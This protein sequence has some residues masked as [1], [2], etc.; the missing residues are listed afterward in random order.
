[1]GARLIAV[2]ASC[3]LA[4]CVRDELVACD[5]GR[6]CPVG[7]AC[8]LVHATCVTPAQT[9]VCAPLVDGDRCDA[10]GTPGICDGN[11]CV[12]GC[13]DGH[14]DTGEECDDG[15]F[16]SRDGCSSA[17]LRE[18]ATWRPIDSPW[19]GRQGHVGAYMAAQK[20]FVVFGGTRGN[21]VLD[22]QWQRNAS[23]TWSPYT[24]TRPSARREAVMV[25]D[26][27][28]Q[29]LVLFGGLDANDTGLDD[30]WEFDGTTWTKMTPAMSPSA[31]WGSGMAFVASSS[32]SILFGGTNVGALSDTWTYDGVTWAPVSLS[33]HPPGR[34][35]HAMTW[36]AARGVVVLYGGTG[37]LF[38]A[39]NDTWELSLAGWIERQIPGP[40]A[41][42]GAVL[43]Y[44][45]ARGKAVLF[46]GNVGNATSDTWEYD[47]NAWTQVTTGLSTPP[48][49]SQATLA[50]DT[51]GEL[52]LVGGAKNFAA[53]ALDDIWLYNTNGKWGDRTPLLTP[54]PRTAPLVYDPVAQRAVLVS[55]VGI[56]L[57]QD[58]WTFDGAW[59]LAAAPPA[60]VFNH[61]LAYDESLNRLV[62]CAGMTTNLQT[63]NTTFAYD[64]ASWSTLTPT[65]SKRVELAFGY[66]ANVGGM[67]MFGGEDGG[68]RYTDTWELVGDTWR[69]QPQA[70]YPHAEGSLSIVYDTRAGHSVLVDSDGVTWAYVDHAWQSLDLASPA[71]AQ[72]DMSL[73]YDSSRGRVVLFES[74][75]DASYLGVSELGDSGWKAVDVVGAAPDARNQMGVTYDRRRRAYVLFGGQNATQTFGDT[76]LLEY[77]SPT[78]D[79]N[80]SNG[81]D[82]DG[83][84]QID[85]VDPDC[86]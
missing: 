74:V 1:M 23:G 70:R 85:S 62:V 31:R 81:I 25:Y 35:E 43:A 76:W 27:T 2:L 29:R 17:C 18:Q 39:F 53:D 46:G 15:N 32:R 3:V 82:D 22:D 52:L 41:R 58:M 73:A 56:G 83:D 71:R 9:T 75:A 47:G 80:C 49:R 86:N 4:S 34:S 72:A 13:G 8:D 11:V 65:P 28:R 42:T 24:G 77:H 45:T 79:E 48:A 26:S 44:S 84:R 19:Q 36:D 61:G 14:Q 20:L 51:S 67:V 64:G 40:S 54:W 5:D 37:G 33:A 78:P 59:R 57:G 50:V 12:P 68:N 16:A 30:T 7:T 10:A 21:V 55:G 38:S 69:E 63:T 60:V 6:L 66:D